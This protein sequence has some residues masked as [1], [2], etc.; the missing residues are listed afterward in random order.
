VVAADLPPLMGAA[1]V[2]AKPRY[3]FN[4]AYS[5]VFRH[6]R[7][8]VAEVLRVPDPEATPEGMRTLVRAC[9]RACVY[10]DVGM[11]GLGGASKGEGSGGLEG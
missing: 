4:R 10:W 5:G 11:W 7:E 6:L 2:V 8:E 3:G 9:V 1:G